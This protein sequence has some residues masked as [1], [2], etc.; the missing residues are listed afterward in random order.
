MIVQRVRQKALQHLYQHHYLKRPG[1]FSYH[2]GL[3]DDTG[4]IVGLCSFGNASHA[5]Q[6]NAFTEPVAVLELNRLILLPQYN[7]SNLGSYL[8]SRAMKQLPRPCAV[9]AFAD[10]AQGHVGYVYQ[11]SNF[12]YTG[13]SDP[14]KQR[15]F[16]IGPTI[17]HERSLYN[18]GIVN[19]I[20]WAEESGFVEILRASAKHRYYYF[21]GSHKERQWFRDNLKTPIIPYPKG[22]RNA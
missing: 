20:T 7:G 11:A 6:R 14:S 5:L 12:L 9:V 4:A 10:T 22:E 19:P 13:L 3:L 15:M 17:Y 18:W 21:L 1:N 16:R 8:I 2:Y